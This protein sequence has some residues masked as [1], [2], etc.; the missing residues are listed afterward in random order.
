MLDGA[1]WLLNEPRV[2]HICWR[3]WAATRLEE[4]RDWFLMCRINGPSAPHLL[5][6]HTAVTRVKLFTSTGGSHGEEIRNKRARDLHLYVFTSPARSTPPSLFYKSINMNRTIP[7]NTSGSVWVWERGMK[8]TRNRN[9]KKTC[10]LVRKQKCF[11]TLKYTSFIFFHNY[12][13][14]RYNLYLH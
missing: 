9:E 10:F 4:K 11:K 13:L 8:M 2:S 7:Q 12:F 5:S 14:K 1:G 6:W 3:I